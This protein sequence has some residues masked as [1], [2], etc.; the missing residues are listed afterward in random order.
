MFSTIID[1]VQ[2]N[3]RIEYETSLDPFSSKAHLIRLIE[4]YIAEINVGPTNVDPIEAFQNVENFHVI[5]RILTYEPSQELAVI[6]KIFSII[7]MDQKIY[8][9]MVNNCNE[10]IRLFNE[11]RNRIEKMVIITDLK[12]LS[13]EDSDDLKTVLDKMNPVIGH[14][15]VAYSD[16]IDRFFDDYYFGRDVIIGISDILHSCQKLRKH[17][18]PGEELIDFNNVVSI[19]G[20]KIAKTKLPCYNSYAVLGIM[21]KSDLPVYNV[22]VV[23]MLLDLMCSDDVSSFWM[24]EIN[25]AVIKNDDYRDSWGFFGPQT[26]AFLKIQIPDNIRQS[27]Y[28]YIRLL[29]EHLEIFALE[30]VPEIKGI[31][32]INFIGV[33]DISAID[34]FLYGFNYHTLIV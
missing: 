28:E 3:K 7:E 25:D 15:D 22:D 16:E 30:H 17:V 5:P 21:K 32:S 19:G 8:P 34:G 33:W 4:G 9:R 31:M 18:E 10:A 11:F 24:K 26:P 20:L 13:L 23:S 27:M 29:T 6:N 12:A 14:P 2:N 1:F